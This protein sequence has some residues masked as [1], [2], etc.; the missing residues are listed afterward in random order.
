MNPMIEID[1]AYYTAFIDLIFKSYDRQTA[2]MQDRLPIG[3]S[4]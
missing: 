1:L 4:D 2:G 3:C